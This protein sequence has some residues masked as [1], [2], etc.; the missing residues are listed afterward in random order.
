[1]VTWYALEWENQRWDN[2]LSHSKCSFRP[3]CIEHLA[4]SWNGNPYS[5][6]RCVKSSYYL[7]KSP[8]TLTGTFNKRIVDSEQEV[9]MQNHFPL[10]NPKKMK[11]WSNWRVEA[12]YCLYPPYL[13]L[14]LTY[15]DSWGFFLP[16]PFIECFPSDGSPV[17]VASF[18]ERQNCSYCQLSKKK[19]KN[20]FLA[21]LAQYSTVSIM[22]FTRASLPMEKT[23]SFNWSFNISMCSSFCSGSHKSFSVEPCRETFCLQIPII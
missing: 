17:L 22:F 20:P 19:W 14:H 13:N 16:N 4:W 1:M 18:S 7:W 5:S 6:N 12:G 15:P 10:D 21:F 3:E 9:G 11:P 2:G 23:M 8:N